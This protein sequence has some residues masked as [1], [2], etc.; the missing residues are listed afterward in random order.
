MIYFIPIIS[1][2]LYRLGG[3][4]H[5]NK[6]YRWLLGIPI[7]IITHNWL[8][9]IT[10]YIA[11]AVFV[12]G[13]NSWVSKLVGRKGARILHGIAFGLAS[14]QPLFAMWTVVIFYI[15]FEMAENNVIDNAWAERLRG[16]F[17][18]LNFVWQ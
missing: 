17:G 13:D 7:A 15:L 5:G 11:T 12:Y 2:V 8:F 14:L 3:S 18:T 4:E 6:W 16:F 1:S 10:Y 9:V